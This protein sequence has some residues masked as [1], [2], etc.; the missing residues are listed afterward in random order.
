MICVSS[1]DGAGEGIDQALDGPVECGKGLEI[2]PLGLLALVVETLQI[3]GANG[4]FGH[5]D[6]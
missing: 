1:R 2:A 5:R 4:P 3:L 6:R